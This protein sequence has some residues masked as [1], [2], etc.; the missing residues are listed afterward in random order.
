M[1]R[2]IP[3]PKCDAAVRHF[4]VT[5]KMSNGQEET[6]EVLVDPLPGLSGIIRANDTYSNTGTLQQPAPFQYRV[7]QCKGATK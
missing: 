7:H 2:T 1:R 4:W 3:C 5:G 6:V